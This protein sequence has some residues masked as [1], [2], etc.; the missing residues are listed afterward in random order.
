MGKEGDGWKTAM[1]TLTF[2]RG[3]SGGQAGGTSMME[4]NAYDVLEL[5][6]RIRRNGKPAIEDT[7]VREKLVSF[8]IE[9]R[10]NQ[11]MSA[12]ERV[13]GLAGDWPGAVPLS[14]KLRNTELRRRLTQF[15]LS[16]MGANAARF[17]SENSVDGG[18]WQRSYLNSFSAT[19]GGGTSE[20][21]HNIVGE[22]VL[23]L[24]KD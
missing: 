15:S 11:L 4:L 20:I 2:E 3:A 12:R 7:Y 16:L 23:G 19:I 24:P 5:A 14:G 9:S 18:K 1:I 6:R 21:Q 13:P 22:R 8:L 10:G 17:V